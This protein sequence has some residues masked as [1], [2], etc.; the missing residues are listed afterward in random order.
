[1]GGRPAA[2]RSSHSWAGLPGGGVAAAG[3]GRQECKHR[4]GEK[5]GGCVC[6]G[7]ANLAGGHARPPYLSPPAPAAGDVGVPGDGGG[8][9]TCV[10]PSVPLHLPDTG[11]GQTARGRGMR[12]RERGSLL[13]SPAESSAPCSQPRCHQLGCLGDRRDASVRLGQELGFRR[14]GC[15]AWLGVCSLLLEPKSS[16]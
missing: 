5:K 7:Q 16:F 4:R 11:T 2:P 14:K 3:A 13:P 10:V 6:C 12:G 8:P 1:M 9:V 15:A